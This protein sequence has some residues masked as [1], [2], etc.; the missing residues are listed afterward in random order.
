MEYG[1]FCDYW[2]SHKTSIESQC[3]SLTEIFTH[4]YDLC[5]DLQTS[6]WIIFNK[7]SLYSPTSS[8]QHAVQYYKL[9]VNGRKSAHHS[10]CRQLVWDTK[11]L[12]FSQLQ[13]N[14]DCHTS[15]KRKRLQTFS[16]CGLS[17]IFGGRMRG[18]WPEIRGP[19]QFYD[20]LPTRCHF[21][22]LSRPLCCLLVVVNMPTSEKC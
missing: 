4:L 2:H 22:Y 9:R 17:R 12:I 6:L 18:P 15:K 21:S 1:L 16:F 7:D 5:P 8:R 20:F 10:S 19:P 11:M 14:P 3:Q 13:T